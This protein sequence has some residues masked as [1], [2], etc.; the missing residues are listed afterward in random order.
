MQTGLDSLITHDLAAYEA[1]A[2]ALGRD[3]AAARG[4]KDH[5]GSL[6]ARY[7]LFDMPSFVAAFGAMLQTVGL[8]ALSSR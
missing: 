6:P 7:A 4:L 1:L 2:V 5:L 8:D 3:R